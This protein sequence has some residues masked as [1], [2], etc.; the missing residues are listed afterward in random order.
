MAE[1]RESPYA[2]ATLGEAASGEDV[3]RELPGGGSADHP[4][5]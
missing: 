1:D 5:R 3:A 4:A 2:S